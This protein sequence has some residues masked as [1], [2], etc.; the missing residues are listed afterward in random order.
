METIRSEWGEIKGYLN[1]QGVLNNAF[2]IRGE[3]IFTDFYDQ[4]ELTHHL[5]DIIC[6]VMIKLGQLVQE[7]QRNSGFA[8]NQFVLA[9]CTVNMVA[10]R[11]YREFIFPYDKRIAENFERFGV[12][13]C[14]WDVTPYLDELSQLAKMGYLDM[15]MMSDLAKVKKLF[16][17]T[18]RAVFYSPVLL[19]SASLTAIETDLKKIYANIA[20]CD[21]IMADIQASTSEE[22]IRDF[23][24][25]CARIENRRD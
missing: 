14:N 12:H 8:I 20:P 4:P 22:R 10:P 11:T 25:I 6:E 3:A 18:R 5:L 16:P 15:G 23:L 7:K 2:H 24:N 9:N 13:T 1:W 17:V 21:V 19:E